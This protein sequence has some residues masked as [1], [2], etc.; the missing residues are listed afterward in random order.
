MLA[1]PS[2]AAL[3]LLL[4]LAGCSAEADH[5]PEHAHTAPRGGLLVE[6]A[7][8]EAHAELLFDA[9]A[10]RVTLY[11][12]DGHAE[13]PLRSAQAAIDL[14]LDAL[15]DAGGPLTL[16]L[17]PVAS[18]LSGETAGDTSRFEAEASALTGAEAF[19]GRI[20]RVELRGASYADVPFAW[21]PDADHDHSDGHDH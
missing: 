9:D 6:L 3:A 7:D 1:H 16:A 20:A 17:L 21:P 13:N 18:D 19:A 11:L 8:H 2:Q 5:D 15:G 12:L 4:T 14:Q 10:G